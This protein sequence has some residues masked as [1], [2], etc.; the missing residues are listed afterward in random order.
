MSTIYIWPLQSSR[1]KGL[2]MIPSGRDLSLMNGNMIIEEPAVRELRSGAGRHLCVTGRRSDNYLL[3]DRLQ[4]KSTGREALYLHLS[5][6]IDTTFAS[7]GRIG[8]PDALDSHMLLCMPS[9]IRSSCGHCLSGA[10]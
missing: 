2:M 6:F 1:N 9:E 5:Q 4:R 3:P 7:V 10:D 8:A